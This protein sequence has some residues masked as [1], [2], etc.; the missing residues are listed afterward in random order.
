MNCRLVTL[1]AALLVASSPV[2]APAEEQVTTVAVMVTG[3]PDIREV[4]QAMGEAYARE[5]AGVKFT[6]TWN[7]KFKP[8]HDQKMDLLAFHGRMQRF[9][10]E[11]AELVRALWG[12]K[13][14]A[15]TVAWRPLVALVHPRNPLDKISLANLR[16]VAEH[17]VTPWHQLGSRRPGNLTRYTYGHAGTDLTPALFP[18]RRMVRVKPP[19][20]KDAPPSRSGAAPQSAEDTPKPYVRCFNEREMLE[21]LSADENGLGL[22]RLIPA[23]QGS[24][25][26]LLRVDAGN[27]PI[28]PSMAEVARGAYP[29]RLGYSVVLHPEAKPE[30]RRFVEWLQG[31]EAATVLASFCLANP[32]SAT[33][34]PETG[35]DVPRT[36]TTT[37]PP[38]NGPVDGAAAVLPAQ[39]ETGLFF[40]AG[41]GH[42]IAY[43]E[44]IAGAIA[45]DGRLK[46]VD[47]EELRRVLAERELTLAGL[48]GDAPQAALAADVIVVPQ[49]VTQGR[50]SYLRLR[51]LHAPTAS[52]LGTL[53]ARID[54]ADPM[55]FDPPLEA[56]VARWWPGVLGRLVQARSHPVWSLLGVDAPDDSDLAAGDGIAELLLQALRDEPHV[57]LAEYE[58]FSATQQEVLMSLMGLSQAGGRRF[59]PAADFVLDVSMTSATAM[60]LRVLAGPE[61]RPVATTTAEGATPQEAAEK[62]SAWVRAQAAALATEEPSRGSADTAKRDIAVRQSRLEMDRCNALMKRMEAVS[63][64]IRRRATEPGFTGGNSEDDWRLEGELRRRVVARLA[65]VVHLD[66]AFEPAARE[67]VRQM[68]FSHNMT[69][70]QM[71]DASVVCSRFIASFPDSPEHRGIAEYAIALQARLCKSVD[72]EWIPPDFPAGLDHA[73]TV[74]RLRAH[75]VELYRIYCERYLDDCRARRRTGGTWIAYKALA[76]GYLHHLSEYLARSNASDVE[77]SRQVAD[78]AAR[79]GEKSDAAPH[80]DFLRLKVLFWKRDKAGWIAWLTDMQKRHPKPKEAYWV[81]GDYYP[82]IESDLISLFRG[83]SGENSFARWR[84]GKRGIGDLP[85]PGYRPENEAPQPK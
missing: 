67:L 4:T 61:F 10:S 79:F 71:V 17:Q 14:P 56:Q 13:V 15:V 57:F 3:G 78:W 50:N 32:A 59:T 22:I 24:G 55:Q 85:Y 31:P 48:S 76:S 39:P 38:Y 49:V 11:D 70:H 60:A 80:S 74:L 69:F 82:G 21:R 40:M 77:V 9:R 35:K 30:A 12:D 19:E 75:Q 28:A 5:H 62:A 84:D 73:D 51:A 37:A 63:T 47:R 65:R 41:A 43:E 2:R 44:E 53:W 68:T 18:D 72:K 34:P 23:A 33:L 6:V 52:A 58:T 46:V 8:F 29:A 81:C 26:K 83:N 45:R 20:K 1:A 27:G 16:Y 7:H 54:A 66:P 42:R 25:L 36:G 64:R